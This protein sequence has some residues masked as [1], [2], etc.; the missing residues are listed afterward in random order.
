MFNLIITLFFVG[1]ALPYC[2][3]FGGMMVGTL[4]FFLFQIL[5][6]K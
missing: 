1:I 2:I 3:I 4:R 6:R 5:G